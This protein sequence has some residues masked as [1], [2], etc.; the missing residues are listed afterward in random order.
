MAGEKER[1]AA[2]QPKGEGRLHLRS[3]VVLE[4]RRMMYGHWKEVVASRTAAREL[5]VGQFD[6]VGDQ[7]AGH[8][9]KAGMEPARMLRLDREQLRQ[10]DLY[11]DHHPVAEVYLLDER[12][13]P[14]LV[15]RQGCRAKAQDSEVLMT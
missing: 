6:R 5:G 12:L 9:S 8:Q 3:L 1:N 2:Q 4:G 15:V 14:V 11:L 13:V 10:P 7:P